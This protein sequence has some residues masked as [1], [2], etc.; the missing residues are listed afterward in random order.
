MSAIPKPRKLTVAEYLAIEAKAE[1][2][3]EFYDGEMFAMAGASPPHNFI[4]ENLSVE[5]GSRLRGSRCRTLSGDQRVMIPRTGLYTYPDLVIVCGRPEF[6]PADPNTLINPVVVVEILS[7]STE[8]YDRGA[9]F[10]QYQKLASVGE[11]VLVSQDQPLV[12]V[13]ARQPDGRWLLTT[14]DDPSGE[15]SLTSVP[16]AVPLADVYRDVEWPDAPADNPP[17]Q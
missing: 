4:K 6:D 15:F 3:S 14:F 17:P 12:Q 16:V 13:F 8:R 9:K 11:I 7:P 1:T 5:V 10:R 2:K